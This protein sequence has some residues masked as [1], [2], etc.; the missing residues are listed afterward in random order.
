MYAA[1]AAGALAAFDELEQLGRDA[2]DNVREAALGE[3]ITLKRPEAALVGLDALGTTRLSARHHGRA[4]AGR[5]RGQ[6]ARRSG[7]PAARWRASRQK[8]ETRRAT[9]AWRFSIVSGRWAAAAG[10]R[11][12]PLIRSRALRGRISAISIPPSRHGRRRSS[13]VAERPGRRR[14]ARRLPARR[15]RCRRSTRSATRDFASPWPAAV[16]FELAPARRRSAALGAAGGHA[17]ARGLLQ[18]PHLPPRRAELRHPGRQPGRQRVHAAMARTCATRSAC[19]S[20]RRGT[21]GIS[22]RGRDTGDAQIFVNLVDSPRLDHT[23]TVFAEVVVGH[24][25]RG[26]DVEGDV[27]ERV[28]VVPRQS[29]MRSSRLPSDLSANATAR[30]AG[31]TPAPRHRDPRSDGVESDARRAS[32]IRTICWR[33]LAS[34]RAR[35]RP[36]AAGRCRSRAR[37]SRTISRGAAQDVPPDRIALTASTS[38]AYALLFKL[39]CDAGDSVLVPRPSYPLFEHLTVLESVDCA[40]VSARIPR[41]R[42]ASTSTICARPSTI[43]TRAVL[44]VSPNNPTGSFLHRDDLAAVAELCAI[45]RSGA[46]RRRSVRRLPAR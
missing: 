15:C 22:T 33:R 3:L 6:G 1:H 28:E 40:A 30:D 31:R 37:Q 23:Y 43:T 42:G 21:V 34:A 13:S 44:V 45:A 17:R 16:P 12:P 7:A 27:I 4:C 39:L 9:P 14:A 20:H 11:R 36:A 29:L 26:R 5:P 24:G 18:R 25:C 2:H 38:E 35:V 19:R 41:R 8:N 46:D 10:G 32:A